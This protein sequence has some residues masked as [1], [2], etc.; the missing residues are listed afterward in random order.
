MPAL[1]TPILEH[2]TRKDGKKAVISG[3]HALRPHSEHCPKRPISGNAFP[4]A[5]L[6]SIF[7]GRLAV[8]ECET[9][10]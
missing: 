5:G 4:W 7:R 9:D 2:P 6:S 10:E 3:Y 8:P 1:Y